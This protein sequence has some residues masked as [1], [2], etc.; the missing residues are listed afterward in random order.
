MNL[1]E[2]KFSHFK[3]VSPRAKIK[4]LSGKTTIINHYIFRTRKI[5]IYQPPPPITVGNPSE[6][7]LVTGVGSE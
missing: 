5:C 3:Y 1:A 6:F 2:W 7:R 4:I